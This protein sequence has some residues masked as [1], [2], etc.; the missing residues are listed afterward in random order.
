MATTGEAVSCCLQA[1]KQGSLLC[2]N[3][4]AARPVR[5]FRDEV[6][7]CQWRSPCFSHDTEHLVGPGAA[8]AEHLLY[9][10]NTVTG[11]LER[12][13]EGKGQICILTT[14]CCH[15]LDV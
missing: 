9:I 2:P 8:K 4:P 13:L 14:L 1:V 6:T 12:I 10:W 3:I 11:G 15:L 7:R 5:E